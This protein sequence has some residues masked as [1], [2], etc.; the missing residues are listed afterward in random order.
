VRPVKKSKPASGPA[1]PPTKAAGT[2][3]RQVI[4]DTAARLF[5]QEGY[6]ATSLRAIAQACDMKAGSLY[7]HFESKDQIVGEVLDIGVQRV[8]DAVRNAVEALPPNADLTATLQCAIEAHLGAL[9]H[10]HDFTSANIRIFG[11][12]PVDVRASHKSLRR[13]YEQYWK[14]VLIAL[15]RKG[16]IRD[17]IDPQ[18]TV[19]FLFGA[20]NWTTEWYDARKSGLAA[21]AGEL[22]DIVANGL[23]SNSASR[24]TRSTSR[25]AKS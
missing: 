11:Q 10:A 1:K 2:L 3:S 18:R 12:V 17:G 23:R 8:F 20:M 16:A 7:Y 25:Q 14:D 15:Q 24:A 6:A 4:L 21:L 13:R 5:R 19:F 9:L 22:A